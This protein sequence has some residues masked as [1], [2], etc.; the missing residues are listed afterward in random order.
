LAGRNGGDLPGR[1]CEE[2]F[3]NTCAFII[4]G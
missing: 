1:I 4:D 3:G 2:G